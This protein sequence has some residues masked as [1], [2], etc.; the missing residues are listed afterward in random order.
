MSTTKIE[1]APLVTPNALQ[2]FWVGFAESS[3]LNSVKANTIAC[4]VAQ[5]ESQYGH[6][7]P[8]CRF[9]QHLSEGV[10]RYH[11]R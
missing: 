1:T 6:E 8:K 5:C 10:A 11:R 4:G 9:A 7:R 3:R 2:G